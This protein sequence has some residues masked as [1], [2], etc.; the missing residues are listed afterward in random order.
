MGLPVFSDS[1]VDCFNRV[2][3]RWPARGSHAPGKSSLSEARD[4]HASPLFVVQMWRPDTGRPICCLVTP[5][6]A[7]AVQAPDFGDDSAPF[8]R[9][10]LIFLFDVFVHSLISM[11]SLFMYS[12]NFIEIFIVRGGLIVILVKFEILHRHLFFKSN[13]YGLRVWGV[14]SS[15][16]KM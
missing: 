2:G 9:L 13:H 4:D 12:S 11:Y 8:C 6:E 3:Y 1:A 10:G 16:L 15:F 14:C 5:G 7:C